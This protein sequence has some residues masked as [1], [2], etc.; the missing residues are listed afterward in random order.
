[1]PIGSNAQDVLRAVVAKYAAAD[2]YSDTGEVTGRI[3]TT[4]MVHRITFSTLYQQPSLF[5]F[6]FLRP[7]PHPPLGHLVTE[8]RVR[9]SKGEH[10]YRFS[11]G[12]FAICR[13]RLV[14]LRKGR[15]KAP[16]EASLRYRCMA[17]W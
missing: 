11:A 17:R 5:R 12:K 6:T 8:R 7:H 1:M 14:G 4:G 9:R 2:S 3:A 10:L 16:R 13:L 15:L